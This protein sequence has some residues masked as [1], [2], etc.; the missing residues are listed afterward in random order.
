MGASEVSSQKILLIHSGGDSKRAPQ[1]SSRGKMFAHLLM[2]G[3]FVAGAVAST[4]LC[5]YLGGKTIWCAEILLA[6][7][8]FA[9]LRADLGEEHDKLDVVPHGH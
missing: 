9:L 5:G 8:F 1:Y 2:I 4:F 3:S 7:V 6:I